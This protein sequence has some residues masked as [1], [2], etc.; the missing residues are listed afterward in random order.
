MILDERP[1]FKHHGPLTER[2]EE[3]ALAAAMGLTNA[4]IGLNLSV[5]ENTVKNHLQA[6]FDKLNVK[7]RREI[8]AALL[9]LKEGGDRQRTPDLAEAHA[10]GETC[11]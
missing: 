11:C 5:S 9:K 1:R 4:D 3:V 2:Q 7:H 10:G 8:K 6:V